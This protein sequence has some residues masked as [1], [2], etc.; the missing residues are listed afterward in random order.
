MPTFREYDPDQ[1]LLLPPSLRDWLPPNHLAWFISETVDQ[2]DLTELIASYRECG[3]GNIAYHPAMMLKVLIYGYATGI[4]SSRK[5]ARQIEENIAFRV[6][7]AG[8]RGFQQ[9]YNGQAAVD[10]HERIVVA[11]SVQQSA[12]DSHA[13]IPLVDLAGKNVGQQPRDVLADAGYA[14]EENFNGLMRRGIRGY[15]PLGRE[16]K[17]AKTPKAAISK[18]MKSKLATV[19]AE[20][21]LVFLALNLRRMAPKMVPG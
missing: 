6:L 20:H 13:L 11:V 1:Q 15:V 8:S 10:S 3:Q 16:G 5:L 17:S 18:R 2:L 14:S 19:T 4:F 9:S 12:A 7:A 21:N